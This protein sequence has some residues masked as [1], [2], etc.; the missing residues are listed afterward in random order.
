MTVEVDQVAVSLNG[1][2]NIGK[3]T[4]L[5]W[6]AHGIPHAHLVGGVDRWDARWQEVASGDFAH[7][8]FVGST[9]AEHV[10]LMMSSHCARRAGS[11]GLA[12]EDRGLPMLRATCAATATMKDALSPTKALRL[13]ERLV[14]DHPKPAPRRE[15]HVL[16]RRSPDSAHEAVEALRRDPM[17]ANDRYSA[18]QRV[19]AEVIALQAERG[20]YDAVLDIGDAPILDVQQQLRTQLA[21]CVEVQPLPDGVL[22][23]LWVLGGLS[24]SGK[25]TVGELLRDEHGVTR[26]KIGYLLEVAALRAGVVDP[27]ERWPEQQQA[28]RLTEEVL[29]FAATSKAR[30]ISLES[31]HRLEATAHLKRIWGE[32]CQVVYVD[33]DMA[34]RARRATEPEAQLRQRDATKLGRGADR[35]ADIADHV[36]DNSGPLSTLKLAL[37][38]IVGAD[39]PTGTPAPRPPTTKPEW[40]KQTTDHL[41][42]EKVALVLAT[43]STGTANWRAGWSDLDL[44][45]VRETAPT[46]WLRHAA[47]NLPATDGIKVGLSVFT[48]ADISALRVPPRVVQ[49]LRYASDGRGVLYRR[50]GYRSPVPTRTHADRTSRGELGL[51]L[52]TTRRL[53]AA[54]RPDVRSIHKHLV[55]LAKILLRADGID[56]DDAEGV[57][58]AF[59][60]RHPAA[61]CTPPALADLVH[62][63]TD[64]AV[65]RQ[66][67]E[68]T[69]RMLAHF[70]QL[71][72][73]RGAAK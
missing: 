24:E 44:L 46:T 47:G 30:S 69:D 29:R 37:D 13:V 35:I 56:R 66:L 18:Y 19:L 53:L 70:D 26:L 59:R 55:L 40:L 58:Q 52:M 32:R 57:V 38:R 17:A 7:W 28:E 48:T 22:N 21:T 4:Q 10:R 5:A 15:I 42:D 72:A 43:G 1:V 31:A 64:P 60:E 45:V 67:V 9:T 51:V 11:N 61:E 12:L 8:W 71:Y 73:N 33:A 36:I 3:T 54:D 62:H 2:D 20:E 34:T 39:V 50:P 6:L 41:I 14:A 16:L 68:A 25:S 65:R 27:Y 49:A 63:P 23:R